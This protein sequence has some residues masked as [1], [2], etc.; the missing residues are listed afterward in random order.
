MNVFEK[1]KLMASNYR[2]SEDGVAAVEA[3]FV[4]PVLLVLLLGVLDTGRG[5]ICNQKTIRASQVVA[6]LITR[7]V[8]VDAGG[9]SEA[10]NA[11]TL[12]LLPY[13]DTNLA[14]DIISVRFPSDDEA[15]IVWQETRNMTATPQN[16][17]IERVLPLAAAGSGVVMVVSEYLYEP[18]FAGFVV[19]QIPMQEVAFARGRRSSV[20]CKDGAPGCSS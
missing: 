13:D 15:E 1:L 16:Q 10:I 17:I 9:I 7:E 12:A 18:I 8:S 19:D 14:F 2:R 5:I 11:G 6:D 4:F 3:A 20:V